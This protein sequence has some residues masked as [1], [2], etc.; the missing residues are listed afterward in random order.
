MKALNQ[1]FGNHCARLSRCTGQSTKGK[2]T[3]KDTPLEQ[4][5]SDRINGHA[6]H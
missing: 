3:N 4:I 2:A 6:E 1:K 5:V